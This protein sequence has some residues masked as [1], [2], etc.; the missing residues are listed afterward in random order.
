MPQLNA[1]GQ[2]MVDALAQRYGVS[3]G[4]VMTLLQALIQ[5]NGRMAQFEH[6]EL[7][8]FGQWM[9]G[10]MT[11]VSDDMFNNAL[12][13]KVDSLCSELSEV[14]VK[15]PFMG[16]PQSS[17]SQSQ[18]QGNHRSGYGETSL[19]VSAAPF[20]HWWPDELGSPTSTGSQNNIRYAFFPAARRLAIEINGQLTLYDTL[21]HQIG[22]VSQQQSQGA[23]LTFTSQRGLVRLAELPL[24][25]AESERGGEACAQLPDERPFAAPPER[26]S[27]PPPSSEDIFGKLERL[28]ELKQKG[29][30]SD[31][32]F[33]TKKAELLARL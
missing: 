7:G 25:S 21:D 1:E 16:G 12:K 22:G 31:E 27:E 20:D 19:F 4:A 33:A 2:R 18:I 11:M 32:E 24:V 5:A 6:L 10:G 17:Q 15:E 14:L 30:L 9:H 3:T 13:A 28:A 26:P 8:G 29:I 23:S